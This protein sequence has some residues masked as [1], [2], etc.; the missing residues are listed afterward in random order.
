M[1]GVAQQTT[2]NLERALIEAAANLE[3]HGFLLPRERALTRRDPV[4]FLLGD[5]PRGERLQKNL[6]EVH[7]RWRQVRDRMGIAERR[8]P[9]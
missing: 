8:N 6:P 3:G 9:G 1:A 4:N 7:D 5:D 2:A